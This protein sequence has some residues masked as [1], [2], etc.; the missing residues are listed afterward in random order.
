MSKKKINNLM[1]YLAF[2]ANLIYAINHGASWLFVLVAVL[3]G[4]VLV[5][6]LLE[7]FRRGRK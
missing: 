4:V 2:I 3:T 5:L 6:D 1:L 7:V